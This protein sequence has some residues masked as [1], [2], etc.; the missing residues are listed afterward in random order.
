MKVFP[1]FSSEF[2]CLKGACPRS[3]CEGWRV[4]IDGET[5]EKYARG[6][7]ETSR[8]AAK[9]L[10]GGK[11]KHFASANNKCPFLRADGLC[12]IVC[13]KGNG[14]LSEVCDMHPRFFAQSGEYEFEYF[15]LSCPAAARLFLRDSL[16]GG[17]KYATLGGA[18]FDAAGFVPCVLSASTRRLSGSERKNIEDLVVSSLSACSYSS[19]SIKGKITAFSLDTALGTRRLIDDLFV[20]CSLA[21]MR[22]KRDVFGAAVICALGFACAYSLYGELGLCDFSREIEHDDRNVIRLRRLTEGKKGKRALLPL[23]INGAK[24]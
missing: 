17:V 7:D 2:A 8:K 1:R 4:V 11:E 20:Y 10:R 9:Y 23:M 14:F 5:A 3:C 24:K 13:E 15:S 18:E 12:E 22:F 16:N 21:F 19:A 6:G